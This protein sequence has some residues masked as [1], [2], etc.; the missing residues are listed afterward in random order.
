M[1]IYIGNLPLEY[2][3][4]ELR[5]MFEA[6]GSVKEATIGRNKK[7]NASEGYGIVVM[8]VKSEARAA[9]KDLRGKQIQGKPLRVTILKPGDIFH[10]QEAGRSGKRIT[11]NSGTFRGTSTIRRGGQRGS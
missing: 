10:T 11:K 5:S 8:S 3:D 9:V 7:T 1:Q 6:F 2:T 4:A